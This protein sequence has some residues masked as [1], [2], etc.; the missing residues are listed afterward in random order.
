MMSR[1]SLI[2]WLHWLS[3]GFLLYFYL[4]EPDENK[5]KPGLGLSTHSGV[6]LILAFITGVWLTCI[7]AK[8]WPGGPD[9]S[10]RDGARNC[11]R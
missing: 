4:V 5:A 2:K 11:I 7:Y 1:R 9:P 6:G 10:C 3:L 8:G